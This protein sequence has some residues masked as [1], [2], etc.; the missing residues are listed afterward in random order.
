MAGIHFRHVWNIGA[1]PQLVVVKTAFPKALWKGCATTTENLVILFHLMLRSAFP[2]S[3][4][5]QSS[6]YLR[7]LRTF[8]V[9]GISSLW[10]VVVSYECSHVPCDI[11][12][13]L[14]T[15]HGMLASPLKC[16]NPRTAGTLDAMFHRYISPVTENIAWASCWAGST[17]QKEG[18][19]SGFR[20]AYKAKLCCSLP[21]DLF[22]SH[23][24]SEEYL[25]EHLDSECSVVSFT[26]SAHGH[27]SFLSA[28]YQVQ[29]WYWPC[30]KKKYKAKHR[31][32]QTWEG[33]K[34][35][36]RDGGMN[37]SSTHLNV[38]KPGL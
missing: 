35:Y 30:M 29:C 10:T 33:F 25:R 38:K 16:T 27:S 24:S 17:I 22:T 18:Q 6:Q 28:E 3:S 13:M 7:D 23:C 15:G 34:N 32:A 14:P 8:P 9:L 36:G 5:S 4:V 20:T 2:P 1:Y 21:S 31:K 26:G 11:I 19:W 37:H 12:A